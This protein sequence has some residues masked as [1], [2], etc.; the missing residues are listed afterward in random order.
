MTYTKYIKY[1]QI[2][3]KI[4]KPLGGTVTVKGP[5]GK[6]VEVDVSALKQ[7]ATQN[8]IGRISSYSK[9][10]SIDLKNCQLEMGIGVK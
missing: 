5:D 4:Y 6:Q 1:I 3:R 7:A 2:Y 10:S 9:H 8:A